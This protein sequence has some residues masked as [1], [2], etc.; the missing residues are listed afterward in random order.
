MIDTDRLTAISSIV[1]ER[2]TVKTADIARELGITNPTARKYL[3]YLASTDTRIQRIH[4]GAAL[5]P[6]RYPSGETELFHARENIH[7]AEKVEIAHKAIKQIGERDTIALDS[8]TTCFELARLLLETDMHLTVI[9]NGIRTAQ[10]LSENERLTVIVCSGV[11]CHRSNTILDEFDCSVYERFNIDIYFFSASCVSI[12]CGFSEYNLREINK[13]RK[14]LALASRGIALIDSSK[15]EQNTS[16]TF[17]QLNE[18][19][20]LITDSK[21][22]ADVRASYE[23]VVDVR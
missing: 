5:A 22:N 6:E 21:V 3:N 13:K 16:S 15:L 20:M 9:T 19:D 10:L 4:G 12:A 1:Y 23:K 7:R 18:A 2:Q 14:C 17:A 11:L 8:S